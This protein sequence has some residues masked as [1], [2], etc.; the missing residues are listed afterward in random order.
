[1][2]K[3]ST[4]IIHYAALKEGV[5]LFEYQLAQEFFDLFEQPIVEGANVLIKLSLHKTATMLVLD[6]HATGTVH[7]ECHRCLEEFEMPLDIRKTLIVKSTGEESDA[8]N[9]D[10]IIAD[11]A[12]EINLAQHLYDFISLALPLKIVHPDD[13]NGNPACN[14]ET[15]K[16]LETLM[17]KQEQKDPRW[18]ALRNINLN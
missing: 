6:I 11:T 2:D 4:Y 9:V 17:V 8:D 12:S 14:P 7:V 10:V 3:L 18:E 15:L 13:E 5:H 1:V 16:K